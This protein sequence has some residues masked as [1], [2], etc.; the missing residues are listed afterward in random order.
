MIPVSEAARYIASAKK[1]PLPT[2]SDSMEENGT[3][4]TFPAD[5]NC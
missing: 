3:A 5:L 4:Y 2:M 1:N